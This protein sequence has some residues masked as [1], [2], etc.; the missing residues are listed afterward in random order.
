MK[1]LYD[2]FL[3][4]QDLFKNKF[5][6]LGTYIEDAINEFKGI[7]DNSK[8]Y[9]DVFTQEVLAKAKYLKGKEYSDIHTYSLSLSDLKSG[10]SEYID[11]LKSNNKN[12]SNKK[13]IDG[14]NILLNAIKILQTKKLKDN[15]IPEGK[16]EKDVKDGAKL[17]LY[18]GLKEI[19]KSP[20][21]EL[22]YKLPEINDYTN[23]NE[24]ISES[25]KATFVK[26]NVLLKTAEGTL[27][28][29]YRS[30]ESIPE[31]ISKQ[32][33]G[34]YNSYKININGQDYFFLC[35][36]IWTP[37]TNVKLYKNQHNVEVELNKKLRYQT[38]SDFDLDFNISES[39]S[40]LFESEN[41]K[42]PGTIISRLQ[43]DL[44]DRNTL[45][46]LNNP[47]HPLY[48]LANGKRN[49]SRAF[50]VLTGNTIIKNDELTVE[51]E[52]E[53]MKWYYGKNIDCE[54]IKLFAYY[55]VDN[56]IPM[57]MSIDNFKSTYSKFEN[58]IKMEN[59]MITDCQSINKTKYRIVATKLD[60]FA[61]EE[62]TEKENPEYNLYS[63][64][65]LFK[66]SIENKTGVKVNLITPDEISKLKYNVKVNAKAWI[67]NGEIYI[68][69]SKASLKDGFHEYCHILLAYFRK[70]IS[71]D[72][73]YGEDYYYTFL[74]EFAK[75][76]KAEE[77]IEEKQKIY[78]N[79]SRY[80]ILEEMFCDAYGQFILKTKNNINSIDELV[81]VINSQFKFTVSGENLDKING[82]KLTSLFKEGLHII[83][84]EASNFTQN[85]FISS[86]V[87]TINQVYQK[88][89]STNILF[90]EP[91][92]FSIER[93]ITN[94]ISELIENGKNN[95]FSGN[96]ITEKCN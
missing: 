10:I 32:P 23:N 64:F 8:K 4:K 95:D 41:Y 70:K 55:L 62:E 78:E 76:K 91:I 52:S 92:D 46:I 16:T 57:P 42:K 1:Q 73:K 3:T 58:E 19:L 31:K 82:N 13:L 40:M 12:D 51:T 25:L 67:H 87:R 45:T 18:Q 54:K 84:E 93:K 71:E 39:N 49:I 37:E 72:E 28:T 60:K 75:T 34:G 44:K 2:A 74:D 15:Q 63:A 96:Y 30:T 14:A 38:T 22:D 26:G 86:F 66:E 80:D 94:L 61:P 24:N 5:E 7:E 35:H 27:E 83:S 11:Y 69:T 88:N 43:Y 47:Q 79:L 65:Q 53:L 33:R 21:R 90:G 50:Y 81:D 36:G 9:E 89:T 29:R 48:Q 6:N 17:T 85:E 56:K 68:N 77:Y 59:I 20:S